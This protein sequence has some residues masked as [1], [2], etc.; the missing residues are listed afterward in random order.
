MLITETI[1]L[2]LI[3][4]SVLTSFDYWY[5]LYAASWVEVK[6]NVNNVDKVENQ[7]YSDIIIFEV[8][9]YRIHSLDA[10]T[11]S[12]MQQAIYVATAGM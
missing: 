2:V 11:Y 1:H 7:D 4:F 3:V 12:Q 8:R 9:W 5:R 10:T 6:E